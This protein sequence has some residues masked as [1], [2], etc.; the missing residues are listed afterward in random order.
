[1][2]RI[3][4]P[5][6]AVKQKTLSDKT[7]PPQPDKIVRTPLLVGQ[8]EDTGG[9]SQ[10]GREI[11]EAMTTMLL[12]QAREIPPYEAATATPVTAPLEVT[13]RDHLTFLTQPGDEFG[14]LALSIEK[15]TAQ[16]ELFIER[17]SDVDGEATQLALLAEAAQRRV[18]PGTDLQ[19]MKHDLGERKREEARQMAERERMMGEES[20]W[21]HPVAG[22]ALLDAIE[23][24][25]R[26]F[27]V[28]PQEHHYVG[29]TLWV[30][31]T[32]VHDA[33]DISTILSITS[34]TK[35]C[36]KTTAKI[37]IE[38]LVKKPRSSSN[39]TPSSLFRLVDAMH[40]TLLID[41]A[42]TFLQLS[43]EMRGLLNAGHTRSTAFVDRC[44]GEKLA[45]EVKSFNTYTPKL[46][47]LIGDLPDTVRDRSIEVHM[48][49]MAREQQVRG[50]RE[51]Y[52]AEFKPIHQ[53]IVRWAQDNHEHLGE[54]DPP[55]PGE[56][57]HRAQDNWRS[58]LAVA[59]LAGDRWFQRAT[60][61]A[62]ALS[63]EYERGE[64]SGGVLI[65]EDIRQVFEEMKADKISSA[66]LV[67]KLTSW[68]DRLWREYKYGR[69]LSQ[70]QLADL[71]RPYGIKPK[72]TWFGGENRNL[73][74]YERDQFVRVWAYYLPS[75]PSRT[76]RGLEN[77]REATLQSRGLGILDDGGGR[78]RGA[79]IREPVREPIL[80]SQRPMTWL[81]KPNYPADGGKRFPV[82]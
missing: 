61:A 74:G 62:V 55:V 25:L 73:N 57:D 1:M 11:Y 29:V 64:T 49:R 31:Y 42:D 72:Q 41:E 32:H 9:S 44:V 4:D 82:N 48:H 70:R 47:A 37:I 26:E 23:A 54:A 28:F 63:G 27:V 3:P 36:G 71:L 21:E 12:E 51:K 77:D 8:G 79:S 53:M 52:R 43:D 40:P 38:S 22:A 16:Y 56:L 66:G 69:P 67:T 13:A 18:F 81:E 39:I 34:P 45:I 30:V 65:L 5:S 19:K 14:G 6:Q 20:P 78:L 15:R 60:L 33:F 10:H 35:R 17:V 59:A 75:P 7:A 58:L 46:L 50:W 76:S 24:K 68:P 80:V 2:L